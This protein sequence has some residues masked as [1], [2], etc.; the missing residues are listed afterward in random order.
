M[1]AKTH[2][3]ASGARWSPPSERMIDGEA[4][5]KEAVIHRGGRRDGKIEEG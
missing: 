2:K 5:V 1:T 4:G 3:N